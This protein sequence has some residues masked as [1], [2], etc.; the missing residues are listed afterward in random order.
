MIFKPLVS[1]LCLKFLPEVGWTYLYSVVTHIKNGDV[2]K[3]SFSCEKD[4]T[5]A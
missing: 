4:K 3:I 2:N 5:F 1:E